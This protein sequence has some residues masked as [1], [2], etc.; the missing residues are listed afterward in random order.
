MKCIT[1][2]E[3]NIVAKY[4]SNN[5]LH[6]LLSQ[7]IV[8]TIFLYRDIITTILQKVPYLVVIYCCDDFLYYV[9][10]QEIVLMSYVALSISHLLLL[11]HIMSH[12]YTRKSHRVIPFLGV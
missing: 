5:L 8:A 9:L 10:L 6:Y 7:Q 12:A 1:K 4:C 3:I 11:N 2:A